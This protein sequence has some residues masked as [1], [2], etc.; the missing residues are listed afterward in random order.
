MIGSK[1]QTESTMNLVQVNDN[2]E[3]YTI[4]KATFEVMLVLALS[5]GCF[6]TLFSMF[7]NPVDQGL[8]VML[9]IFVPLLF[10]FLYRISGIGRY[11]I[12]YVF[13]AVA[14]F[15]VVMYKPVWNGLL[16]Y[17]NL[18]IEVLNNQL[19]LG[20]IGFE[21]TGDATSLTQ[22]C[23]C[24]L[25]PVIIMISASISY[26]VF[27]KEPA[28]GLILTAIPVVTGLCLK[29][30]PS[31]WLL[32]L[33]FLAWTGLLVLSAVAKPTSTKRNKPIYVQ[34]RI[35][36][37]LPL[38]FL[39]IT[40]ALLLIMILVFSDSKYNPPKTVDELKMAIVEMEEHLRY[41]KLSGDEIDGLS[42]GDL[43]NTHPI[44]YTENV[45]MEV[46][47]DVPQSM[48][49]R[50]FVGGFYKE[51]KWSSSED[52]TFSGEYKG[53]TQWLGQENFYPWCQLDNLYRIS[54]EYDL[55]TVDIANT[56]GNS[57][58][59]YIPYEAAITSDLTPDKVNYYRDAGLLSKGMLGDREYSFTMFIPKDTSYDISRL[60]DWIST[61]REM[62]GYSE[63]A[64]K[65]Q[66]Y[67]RFVYD[68]YMYLPDEANNALEESNKSFEKTLGK[69]LDSVI[70][71]IREDLAEN[72]TYDIEIDKA[73]EGQ[74]ELT[75]F[76]NGNRSGNDM[77][78]AT[79]ATLMFRKA[80][81]AARYAEGYYISPER[82]K[83]Y[84]ELD[85]VRVDVTDSYAH[86]WVEVY[87]D[88]VGWTPV[89]VIPG[90][91]DMNKEETDEEEID[92]EVKQEDENFVKND[93][94]IEEEPDEEQNESRPLNPLW[95][96]LTGFILTMILYEIIGRYRM[97]KLRASFGT[98]FS[99]KQIYDIYKYTNRLFKLSGIRLSNNPYDQAEE[100]SVAYDSFTSIGFYEFLG[101][102]NA[103]RF[104]HK[105]INE[106]T[107][108]AIALY[109]FELNNRIYQTQNGFKKFIMKYVL[110][111]F[112]KKPGGN[113]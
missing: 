77:H 40:L 34:S 15:F 70:F 16:V 24:A 101:V 38:I 85:N 62:D 36:S 67:R 55:V 41:D 3:K 23:L 90:F 47:M 102:V 14:L 9:I 112:W 4:L 97:N 51:G 69:D 105:E 82:I 1:T 59:T 64:N 111:L 94:P 63:Y 29:A 95:F 81:F 110:F 28:L 33:L 61:I 76:L 54:Q 2:K 107:H 96:V 88:E 22:D 80:G 99:D 74:D 66:V 27:Y 56:G 7:P 73:P 30:I 37:S 8:S 48:Y 44:T 46:R 68:T 21:T 11:I 113:E 104:G 91:Y 31:I 83:L 20:V 12:F 25:V 109:T 89:E 79:A 35:R 6:Y 43:T 19:A 78:F 52:K 42:R 17:A 13:I 58:Y 45:V 98:V 106:E 26:S 93:T 5:V 10:Y 65:E 49:L 87:V 100:V 71:A 108:K 39:T 84:T 72:Y 50:G 92:E 75:Y 57:K 18:V 32:A 103:V 60:K 53:L 86:S